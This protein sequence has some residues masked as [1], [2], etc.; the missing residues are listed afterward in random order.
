VFAAV[1]LEH[2]D[3]RRIRDVLDVYDR[4]NP[5]ALTALSVAHQRLGAATT[6]ENRP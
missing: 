4:T 1:G 3:L 2:G 5:M 6:E